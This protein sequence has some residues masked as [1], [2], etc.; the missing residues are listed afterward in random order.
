MTVKLSFYPLGLFFILRF[1]FIWHMF[2]W[3]HTRWDNTCKK[4]NALLAAYAL[5]FF[6]I[7]FLDSNCSFSLQAMAKKKKIKA[8]PTLNHTRQKH[9]VPGD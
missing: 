5:Q 7:F 2:C 6:T 1:H 3:S 9:L 4:Q 8:K